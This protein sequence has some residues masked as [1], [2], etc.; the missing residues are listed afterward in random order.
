MKAI[1]N[2]NKN[3]A[4]AKYNGLTFCTHKMFRDFIEL[5]INGNIVDFKFDEIIIVD[6][7]EELKKAYEWFKD[8]KSMKMFYDYFV[9][10]AEVNNIK[11]E[12]KY[13][14]NN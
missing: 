8:D 5:D 7:S 11:T 4:Y 12:E 10:Y 3:S 9:N 6:F 14:N 2:V 13:K 1:I